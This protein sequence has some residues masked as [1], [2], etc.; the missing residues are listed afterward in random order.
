MLSVIVYVAHRGLKIKNEFV[1]FCH[2]TC[3]QM[4]TYHNENR[5]GFNYDINPEELRSQ[6]RFELENARMRSV[7]EDYNDDWDNITAYLDSKDDRIDLKNSKRSSRS[8]STIKSSSQQTPSESDSAEEEADKKLD[9]ADR[10]A[11]IDSIH[12]A[13]RVSYENNWLGTSV[14]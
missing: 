6:R 8:P 4:A 1:V 14:S 10:F 3:K 13:K 2:L 11:S 9:K 12:L 5:I 7:E